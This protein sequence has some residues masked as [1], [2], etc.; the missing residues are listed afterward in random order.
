MRFRDILRSLA[1]AV[2]QS[3]LNV[4]VSEQDSVEEPSLM[5]GA[6][7]RPNK[8]KAERTQFWERL[9]HNDWQKEDGDLSLH[10]TLVCSDA[11][12]ARDLAVRIEQELVP[13]GYQPDVVDQLGNVVAVRLTTPSV[14]ELMEQDYA[15]AVVIDT[16]V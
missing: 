6:P 2:I 16:C 14:G 7:S 5:P 15:A 11:E 1:Q 12:A 13:I 4:F 10:R 9:M 3:L 8:M